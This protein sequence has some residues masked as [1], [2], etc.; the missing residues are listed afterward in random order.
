MSR[1]MD[2]LVIFGLRP[3]GLDSFDSQ[4]YGENWMSDALFRA[5]RQEEYF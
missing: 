1:I 4:R 2:L 3:P 5:K